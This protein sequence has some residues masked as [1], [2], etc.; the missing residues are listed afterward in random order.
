MGSLGYVKTYGCLTSETLFFLPRTGSNAAAEPPDC[1]G[2]LRASEGA[3]HGSIHGGAGVPPR[4]ERHAQ[5]AV[6]YAEEFGRQEPGKGTVYSEKKMDASVDGNPHTPYD[7]LSCFNR[8]VPC[9]SIIYALVELPSGRSIEVWCS[10]GASQGGVQGLYP[11]KFLRIPEGVRF[12]PSRCT[13]GGS[14]DTRR[15]ER[16]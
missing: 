14:R 3:L 13:F 8:A 7:L 15:R 11:R 10:A 5:H 6:L 4:P 12:H 16:A 1:G 2:Q 9:T